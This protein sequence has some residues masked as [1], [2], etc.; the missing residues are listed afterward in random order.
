[1]T[2]L[3]DCIGYIDRVKVEFHS[4]FRHM[5]EAI[6]ALEAR[7]IELE[8]EIPKKAK[9]KWFTEPYENYERKEAER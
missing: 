7:I 8:N 6:A 2:E 9:R 3:S 5:L 1:M 4:R